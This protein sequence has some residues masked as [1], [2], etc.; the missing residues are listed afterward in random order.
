MQENLVS[1]PEF[2]ETVMGFRNMYQR[3]LDHPLEG[4]RKEAARVRLRFSRHKEHGPP[5]AWYIHWRGLYRYKYGE[6]IADSLKQWGYVFWHSRRLVRSNGVQAVL[7][8]RPV[9]PPDMLTLPPLM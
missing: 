8:E 7:R 4:D 2:M 3:R 5:L 9:G 1:S 6:H